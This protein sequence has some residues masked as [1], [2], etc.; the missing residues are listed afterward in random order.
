MFKIVRCLNERT[1]INKE[2]FA[3]FDAVNTIYY[4]R[5]RLSRKAINLYFAADAI[6][7]PLIRHMVSLNC[8]S[9]FE[10]SDRTDK[11][12]LNSNWIVSA[13]VVLHSIYGQI[14]SSVALNKP[15][16]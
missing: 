7:D 9:L 15:E 8:H 10:M 4:Q 13:K 3:Y 12:I 14:G 5:W 11:M 6:Q 2:I 1:N 16:N